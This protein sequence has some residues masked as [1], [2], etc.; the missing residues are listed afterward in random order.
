MLILHGQ[1]KF[2]RRKAYCR[3]DYCT[4]C[5]RARFTE[6]IRSFRV[7]HIFYIPLIP[8]GFGTEWR[9]ASCGKDPYTRRPISRGLA[10]ASFVL[11]LLLLAGCIAM[12][13]EERRNN[14]AGLWLLLVMFGGLV[15]VTANSLSGKR[16]FEYLA[17]RKAVKP[18]RADVCPYCST[19][20]FQRITIRCDMCN[21]TI[22]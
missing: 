12:L 3:N 4:I 18:L 21:I 22:K 2:G 19:P 16:R 10:I 15:F 1:Y 13:W 11:S 20:T 5:N 6:G 17:R 8:I 7:I 14:P 9:C